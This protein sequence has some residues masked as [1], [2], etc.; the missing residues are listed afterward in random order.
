MCAVATGFVPPSPV[1]GDVFLDGR[2]R[3]LAL[4]G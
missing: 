1:S 2:L 3:R 4:I